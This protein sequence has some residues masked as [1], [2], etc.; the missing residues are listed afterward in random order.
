MKKSKKLLINYNEIKDLLEDTPMTITELEDKVHHGMTYLQQEINELVI[1]KKIE[2]IR[3]DNQLLLLWTE[4]VPKFEYELSNNVINLDK[5]FIQFSTIPSERRQMKF[6]K[7]IV[8]EL[9]KQI[10]NMN[11]EK[12]EMIL[13]IKALKFDDSWHSIKQKNGEK[14]LWNKQK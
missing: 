9:Q 2:K 12:M 3:H 10:K 5:K 8:E 4:I 14:K 1:L 11:L 6:P 13:E 7:F